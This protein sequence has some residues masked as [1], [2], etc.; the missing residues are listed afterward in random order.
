MMLYCELM[1]EPMFKLYCELMFEVMFEL[2]CELMPMSYRG[3]PAAIR[4]VPPAH[5]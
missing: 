2:Y 3:S 1:F 5:E 4:V